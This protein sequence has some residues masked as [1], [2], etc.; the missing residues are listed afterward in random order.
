MKQYLLICTLFFSS[1]ASNAE[2][3]IVDEKI[4]EQLDCFRSIF[5]DYDTWRSF[6]ES[7]RKKRIKSTEKLAKGM[8][9]FDSMFGENKFNHYRQNLSCITFKYQVDGLDIDG[10]LIKPKSPN[11]K[12]LPVLV[13]NR[14]GNGSFGSVVFGSMMHNLFPIANEGF[15][16]IGSQYRQSSSKDILLDEF[17]GKDVNDVT[18]LLKYIPKIKNADS[19]RIGM[20]GESRGGMQTFLAAKHSKF[21]KAIATIASPT[22]LLKE[23][24]FRPEMEKVFVHRIPNYEKNK[25]A[26]LEKRS[27]LKWVDQLPHD[28]PIL[29][30]HG[31]NDK[32]VS[33]NS[34]IELA[35][36]LSKSE[37]P[38]KLVVYPRDDH[39]LM[40]NKAAANEELV[41]WFKKYL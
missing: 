6:I 40:N 38:H 27:V 20:F 34:S 11:K 19:N 26:E 33:V 21:I 8:A 3:L 13:Y 14:G 36:A 24:D 9:Q 28:V 15:V 37:I 2:E 5:S 18:E 7:Q 32:R 30:L 39:G 31:E 12:T 35:A 17:G 1:F 22:D 29:L 41:S 23:L 4:T 25:I 16:I 10:Y